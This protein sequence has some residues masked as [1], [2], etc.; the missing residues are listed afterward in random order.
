MSINILRCEED[1][2]ILIIYWT[3][4]V[5]TLHVYNVLHVHDVGQLPGQFTKAM[6]TGGWNMEN[7]K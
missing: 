2:N 4:S 5:Q 1:I 7:H 6:N 3:R